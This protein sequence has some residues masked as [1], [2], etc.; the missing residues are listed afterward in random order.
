MAALEFTRRYAMAHRLLATQSPKCAIPHGHN[1]FV[2]VRLDAAH[3]VPLR[4]NELD[5]AVRA[6][7]AALASV[8]RRAASITRCISA[9]TI[10]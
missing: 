7:E 4:R 9:K 10:R 1:E 5:R 3:P 2:T 6:G 8:D